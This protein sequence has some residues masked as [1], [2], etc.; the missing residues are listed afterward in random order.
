ML[1]CCM[2]SH[3]APRRAGLAREKLPA[4]ERLT[5]MSVQP[6][7]R[8]PPSP[9]QEFARARPPP[10]DAC[11]LQKGALAPFLLLRASRASRGACAGSVHATDCAPLCAPFCIYPYF[12]HPL[13]STFQPARTPGTG[14]NSSRASSATR[15][16]MLRAKA[17]KACS[18]AGRTPW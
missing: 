9:L 14:D 11:S 1:P 8:S 2:L 5:L 17:R 4:G 6:H 3:S 13:A 7:P 10:C 16:P 12:C 18:S 15:P